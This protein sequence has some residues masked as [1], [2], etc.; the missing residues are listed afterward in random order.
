MSAKL[1][2]NTELKKCI[3][4]T[5]AWTE[6]PLVKVFLPGTSLSGVGEESWAVFFSAVRTD[7][8]A[9]TAA[10]L[11]EPF[12][13]PDTLEA[14]AFFIDGELKADVKAARASA[15]CLGPPP[16]LDPLGLSGL[17]KGKICIYCTSCNNV[18]SH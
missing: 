9:A 10:A 4:E 11:C 3:T 6:K 7:E 1:N 15:L 18:T 12:P 8:R 16:W 14:D 17:C 13:L 5:I 2:R